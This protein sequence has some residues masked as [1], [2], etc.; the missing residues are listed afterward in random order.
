M[1]CCAALISFLV[2]ITS[3]AELQ[4]DTVLSPMHL[5]VFIIWF[6]LADLCK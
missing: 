4:F 3:Q 1:S 5:F 6:K 2:W